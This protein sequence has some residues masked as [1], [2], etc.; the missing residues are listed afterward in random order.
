MEKENKIWKS[1]KDPTF[2]FSPELAKKLMMQKYNKITKN[3]RNN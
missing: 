2:T 3:T 1:N